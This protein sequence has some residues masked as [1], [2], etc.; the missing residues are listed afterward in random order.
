MLFLAV[1]CGFLAEN[2]REHM[3]EHQREKKYIKS[4]VNDLKADRSRLSFILKQ[5]ESREFQLDSFI[6]LLNKSDA[7][8]YSRHLYYL[9]SMAT[10]GWGFRY[11]PVDG[12]LQQLKNAGNLRLIRK[13]DVTDSILAYDVASR[14][15]VF[16]NIDEEEI[17]DT[18]RNIAEGV[19]DGKVLA[20]MRDDD[21]NLFRIDY[22]P[23]LRLSEDSKFRLVYRV[24][25]LIA[26][27]N[28]LKKD[29]RKLL[30]RSI[31]L[32]SMLTKEYHL[33]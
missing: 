28:T 31:M 1:F 9:N 19:F 16:G 15:L 30:D 3:V 6:T 8:G 17:M 2:Q 21:N 10:R 12:T 27:N 32:I 25:M 20:D 5:R 24:H 26:F 22:D 4:F 23:S 29:V 14:A 7:S 13:A 18:Y 11:T 33:E